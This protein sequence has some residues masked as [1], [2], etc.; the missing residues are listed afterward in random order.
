MELICCTDIY[1]PRQREAINGV[2]KFKGLHSL[3]DL[4]LCDGRTMAP[5]ALSSEPSRSKQIFL[6]ERPT[7]ADFALFL[8]AIRRCFSNNTLKYT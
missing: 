8:D 3:A 5:F 4:V 1:T 6:V 2:R 7:R